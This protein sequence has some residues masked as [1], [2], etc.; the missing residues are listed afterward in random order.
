MSTIIVSQNFN[1]FYNFDNIVSVYEK[2]GEIFC[3]AT[4]GNK[5]QLG[6]YSDS[7]L[8]KSV[9]IDM[10]VKVASGCKI[11]E[12]PD[13]EDAA[14]NLD[15]L[16]RGKADILNNQKQIVG[17]TWID[18]KDKDRWPR[19]G[20]K[21]LFVDYRHAVMFGEAFYT[22]EFNGTPAPLFKDSVHKCPHFFSRGEVKYWMPIPPVPGE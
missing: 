12:L 10:D 9:L 16:S 8:A 14:E 6:Y 5:H 20:E 4:D 17:G 11:Y 13:E 19:Q 22:K 21:A 1:T 18:A 7:I 3:T 15:M 2:I